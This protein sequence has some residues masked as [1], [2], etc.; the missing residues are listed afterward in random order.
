M[1]DFSFLLLLFAL[2]AKQRLDTQPAASTGP[3][4]SLEFCS[5]AANQD[6][7]YPSVVG[8]YLYFCVELKIAHQLI[9]TEARHHRSGSV[10][11]Q[12]FLVLLPNCTCQNHKYFPRSCTRAFF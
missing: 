9:S 12:L 6:H 5:F 2:K 4:D 3:L 11:Q 1:G 10:Y 7:K 8:L